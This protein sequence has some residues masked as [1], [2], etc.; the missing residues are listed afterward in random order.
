MYSF[1]VF[2]TLITRTTAN[3]WGIFALMKDRLCG[4]KKK[5]GL[6]DYV[7][8]NFFE[9]RIHSEELIRK[10]GSFQKKEEVTLH[11]IYTAMT[12]CG[13]LDEE[14]IRYLCELEEEIEIANAVGI[15]PN[16]QR[17]KGVLE[18]GERVILVSDMYLPTDTIRRM[19]LQTD[20][21]FR[22]LPI[23][24]S[25]EQ[26][27]RKTTGNLYRKVQELEGVSY[28]DWTHIGDNLHQDIEIPYWMGIKV[29][30]YP[31][32]EMTRLEKEI[33][34][35]YGDDSKLQ[36]MI[37]TALRSTRKSIACA[38]RAVKADSFHIGCRYAGPVLYSYAEWIV[39]QAEKKGMKRLY[40]IARDGYLVKKIVDIILKV[41]G[42]D[43]KTKYIYGSR[44]A[45]RIP[46]LSKEHYNL[47]QLVLWSHVHRIMTL[48]ELAFV[49]HVPLEDLYNF[50]PGLYATKKEDACISNQELE[51]IAGRLSEDDNFKR[52]HLHQLAEERQIAQQYLEQEVDVTDD[53]F[54]FVDV[55]GG[56]LTQGCLWQLLKDIYSKPIHTF[57]FKIDRVNLVENSITDTF[58][59]GF[60]ENNL[61]VE[62]M[63]RA[64]HGQTRGYLRKGD[65]IA[66]DL[67]STESRVLIEYG[68][69]EYEK[70]I[71]EFADRMCKVS[72]MC[73][74]NVASMRN[75]L[76]Y[77]HH[78]AQNPSKDV[79]EYFASM[80]SSESGRGTEVIEYA[81]RLTNQEIEDIF[82][83]RTNE[84]IEYFYK[85]T[86]LNYSVM[87]ATEE[88]KALIEQCKRERGSILGRLYREKQEQSQKE[89][90]SRYGRA[91]FYPIRLL[92]EKVILYGAGKFGQD[93]YSRLKEDQEHEVVLWVDKKAEY[94]RQRGLAEVCDISKIDIA[95]NIK[96]VIAVM[97]EEVADGIRTELSLMGIDEKR[98]VWIRPY[99]YPVTYVEWKSE[100]IG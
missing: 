94:C 72:E 28:E 40:F 59:P 61:T 45:W 32:L 48:S 18:Q 78:I 63:C 93:L 38:N 11:D 17:L 33:L 13:C 60:L 89:L 84:P 50:L 86:D 1:D 2:D 6:E 7:I 65:N 80:P 37:G 71:L 35:K 36:M 73:G 57:F 82:F 75:V 87:R 26:G 79:L 20:E 70:G 66:P 91:A 90:V 100:G 51:Y 39:G 23:Y 81:P 42:L 68:F 98:I 21:V 4:E 56:G 8:D 49:L 9:L 15:D 55:S 83:K 85:G 52:Y 25:S 69:Y 5:N 97:S 46:S 34:E 31:K 3:P 77:L 27:V 14:Q 88:E 41:K 54:A 64:P 29:E 96:V 12:V 19:L 67:E 95:S 16:I 30:L 22:E 76:L 47:Y 99:T 62:M 24:V 74:M 53:S 44:K 10:A 58:M 43:I 92:D